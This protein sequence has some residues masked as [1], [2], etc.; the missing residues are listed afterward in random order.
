MK[1]PY[2]YRHILDVITDILNHV[3]I[4]HSDIDI[5]EQ[6]AAPHFSSNGRI[7]YDLIGTIGSSNPITWNGYVT[8][9]FMTQPHKNG[10]FCITRT[11]TIRMDSRRSLAMMSRRGLT[12]QRINGQTTPTSRCGS[13]RKQGNS[14][15]VMGSTGGITTRRKR[16]ANLLSLNCAIPQPTQK[17]HGSSNRYPQAATRTLL[18]RCR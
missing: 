1:S 18:S 10:I 7:N 12:A 8:D 5:P 9:F 17:W 16:R 4:T 15:F 13:L 2:R 6:D 14:F 11:G 3:G